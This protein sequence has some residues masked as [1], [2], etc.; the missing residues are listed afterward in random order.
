MRGSIVHPARCR[1][2]CGPWCVIVHN[3]YNCAQIW[4]SFSYS[5]VAKNNCRSYT[6]G[7]FRTQLRSRGGAYVTDPFTTPGGRG[8]DRWFAASRCLQRDDRRDHAWL[9]QTDHRLA[10]AV[11]WAGRAASGRQPIAA[12][13]APDRPTSEGSIASS[14]T[15]RFAI[16]SATPR[17]PLTTSPAK[18][19]ARLRQ[20]RG[21]ARSLS[22]ARR[23][24]HALGRDARAPQR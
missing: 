12:N 14:T 7:P 6:R 18:R 21:G 20:Q 5:L 23:A 1:H 16:C 13:R 11:A 24:V 3:S 8:T 15:T 10:P 17:I 19:S 22:R 2:C 9:G 4:L